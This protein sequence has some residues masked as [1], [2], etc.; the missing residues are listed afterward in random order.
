MS[1]GTCCTV[2]AGIPAYDKFIFRANLLIRT[3]T[4][5]VSA[6]YVYKSF[7]NLLFDTLMVSLGICLERGPLGSGT[8]VL[9][10]K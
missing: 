9:F 2:F 4:V 1:A 5:T 6:F 10:Q 7:F 3:S 8:L